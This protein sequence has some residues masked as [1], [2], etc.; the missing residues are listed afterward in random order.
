MTIMCMLFMLSLIGPTPSKA[1]GQA[2]KAAMGTAVGVAG[3][4]VITMSVIVARAR[5]QGEY[6]DAAEDLIHWQSLPMLLTPAV[7]L[8][9]GIGGSEPLKGSVIG[10]TSGM[11]IGAALG[12]GVGWLTSSDPEAPWAGGAIGAGLGMTAGGLYL[13][14]R[15]WL[16]TRDSDAALEAGEPVRVGIQLPLP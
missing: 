9:F 15:N 12:A 8:A 3:G 7:G 2:A 10:S 14:I 6:I 13:G 1:F 11:A 5:F 16:R 4:A